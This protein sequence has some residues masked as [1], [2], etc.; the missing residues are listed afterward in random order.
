MFE[1]R[2]ILCRHALHVLIEEYDVDSLPEKYIL[3]RW[4]KDVKRYHS[5]CKITYNGWIATAEQKKYDEL[6]N[7]FSKVADLGATDDERYNRYKEW[8]ENELRVEH[9]KIQNFG[10]GKIVKS[11]QQSDSTRII[12]CAENASEEVGDPLCKTPKGRPRI[13]P[14]VKTYGK[15][16]RAPQPIRKN[17]ENNM[18]DHDLSQQRPRR[19]SKK[20]K[21]PK[22]KVSEIPTPSPSPAQMRNN[23]YLCP[24][25]A[26]T[27]QF[28]FWGGSTFAMNVPH[29]Y[30][31][32]RPP[33]QLLGSFN[34]W[35]E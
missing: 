28:G 7:L 10:S 32:P 5:R 1:F 34:F 31:M 35:H 8:V 4:R 6:Q 15:G 26:S 16:K 22:E 21:T 30:G 33:I 20:Q 25:Q 24:P 12:D 29:V 18:S 11:T 17:K 27:D 14:Y 19:G 2:G 9:M 13:H 3:R 23:S